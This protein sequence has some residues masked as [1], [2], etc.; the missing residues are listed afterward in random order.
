[1]H[2][3]CVRMQGTEGRPIPNWLTVGGILIEVTGDVSTKTADLVTAKVLINEVISTPNCK[4]TALT[5][6]IST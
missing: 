3:N 5:S 6:T 2:S 1:M 4:A